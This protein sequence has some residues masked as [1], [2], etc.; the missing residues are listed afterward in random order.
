MKHATTQTNIGSN[1]QK[2]VAEKQKNKHKATIINRPVRSS[3]VAI[4]TQKLM[5]SAT[6][7]KKYKKGA[8]RVINSL[9]RGDC[10]LCAGTDL[11]NIITLTKCKHKLCKDCMSNYIKITSTDKLNIRCPFCSLIMD[12]YKDIKPALSHQQFYDIYLQPNLKKCLSA[13]CNNSI[14]LIGTGAARLDCSKCAKSWCVNCNVAW[15]VNMD[16]DAY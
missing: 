5:N 1:W 16:C 14:K 3:S 11:S 8:K 15:H 4:L 12:R 6:S 10:L 7:N 9:S 2:N 13:N